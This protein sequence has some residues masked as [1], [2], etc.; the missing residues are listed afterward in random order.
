M[1]DAKVIVSITLPGRIMFNQKEAEALEEAQPSSGFD[2]HKKIA[3]NLNNKDK[4]VIHYY[5]RKCKPAY[6]SVNLTKEAYLYMID[7]FSCPEWEK[8]NKWHTMSKKE[9]LESH[10]QRLIEHLRGTSFTYTVF[11]D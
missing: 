9:R 11:V 10:L 5:T 2:K 1:I 3:E 6:Q 8:N 4:K 7:K